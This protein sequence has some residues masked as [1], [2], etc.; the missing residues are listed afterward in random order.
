MTYVTR[1]KQKKQGETDTEGWVRSGGRGRGVS[2][3][4]LVQP[5]GLDQ[6]QWLPKQP[7]YGQHSSWTPSTIPRQTPASTALGHHLPCQGKPRPAQLLDTICHAKAN[8]GQHSSWTP[9]AIPRQT[10]AST[11]L[12]HHLPCQGKPRP[13]KLL[14]VICH[15]KWGPAQP[16][17]LTVRESHRRTTWGE[18]CL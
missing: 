12:G 7:P 15:A 8:P 16:G 14:V 11:A 13:A 9:S 17:R 1:R 5:S 18:S 4:A 3:P 6:S 10:P 2:L